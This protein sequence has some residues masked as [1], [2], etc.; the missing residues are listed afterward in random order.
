MLDGWENRIPTNSLKPWFI[1]TQGGDLVSVASRPYNLLD[2]IQPG[3][4][5]ILV[6]TINEFGNYEILRPCADYH[7]LEG[8]TVWLVTSP[9][10]GA[11]RRVGVTGTAGDF[12]ISRLSTLYKNGRFNDLM[13]YPHVG[14]LGVIV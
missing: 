13:T 12:V 1:L 2:D 8:E 10:D 4:F 6:G 11:S 14:L 7:Q 9:V 5:S 3:D